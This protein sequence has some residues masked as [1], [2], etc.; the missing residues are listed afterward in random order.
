[1]R[2]W[3]YFKCAEAEKIV[4]FCRDTFKKIKNLNSQS[5]DEATLTNSKSSRSV[6]MQQKGGQSRHHLVRLCNMKLDVR[7]SLM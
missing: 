1:M 3:V 2:N 7:P 4:L 5:L 6:R